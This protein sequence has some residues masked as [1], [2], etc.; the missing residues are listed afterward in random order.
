M[1]YVFL[2]MLFYISNIFCALKIKGYPFEIK[3]KKWFQN[4]KLFLVKNIS[5]SPTINLR[6]QR[7]IYASYIGN[8]GK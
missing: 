3:K 5:T 8:V 4:H 7:T 2:A 1:M 6:R